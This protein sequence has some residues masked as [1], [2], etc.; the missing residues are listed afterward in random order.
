M[1]GFYNSKSI[2]LIPLNWVLETF[3]P[4]Y[5]QKLSRSSEIIIW[6]KV[7]KGKQQFAKE[8]SWYVTIVLVGRQGAKH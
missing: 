8:E 4:W 1:T 7:F 2:T 6:V 3:L 5:W